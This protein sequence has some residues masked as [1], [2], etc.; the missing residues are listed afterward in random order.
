MS[1]ADPLMIGTVGQAVT[2]SSG[3]FSEVPDSLREKTEI[4]LT[5]ETF[6][7]FN[8]FV[9]NIGLSTQTVLDQT[10]NDVDLVGHPLSIGNLVGTQA[11]SLA[12]ITQIVYTYTPYIALGDEANAAANGDETNDGTSYQEVYSNAD[13]GLDSIELTGLFLNVTFSGPQ[14]L[15]QTALGDF[16][17]YCRAHRA[18]GCHPWSDLQRRRTASILARLRL[19]RLHL[20]LGRLWH[21]ANAR[22]RRWPE[23]RAGDDGSFTMVLCEGACN[24][25]RDGSV[26]ACNGHGCRNG[27]VERHDGARWFR[28]YV[29]KC[30]HNAGGHRRTAQLECFHDYRPI[31]FRDR[32]C[33]PRRRHFH[34]LVSTIKSIGFWRC[35][36]SQRAGA[37][38]ARP[39][40]KIRL[41][42]FNR[43]FESNSNESALRATI[44]ALTNHAIS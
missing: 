3:S 36:A 1:D 40:V 21:V 38:P 16:D 19:V 26:A 12:G 34:G 24:P 2:A 11:Q 27:H 5:A 14:G 29:A 22:W 39:L 15:Y 41:A 17:L 35:V 7:E 10:F 28:P 9:S 8:L 42:L 32:V 23:K 18:S 25:D 37:V 31:A 30:D 43:T 6:S 20:P 44:E 4:Q 13:G 33:L